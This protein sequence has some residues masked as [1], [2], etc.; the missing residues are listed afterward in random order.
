MLKLQLQINVLTT[1]AKSLFVC[2]K[3]A[4]YPWVV[5]SEREQI[6]YIQIIK[7]VFVF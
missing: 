5:H 3:D 6:K 1:K 7:F 2:T 4:Y